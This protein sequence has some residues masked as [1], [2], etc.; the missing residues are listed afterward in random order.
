[1]ALTAPDIIP[2]IS[3]YIVE[4]LD[5]VWQFVKLGL[6][7]G[8]IA[9]AGMVYMFDTRVNV[10]EYSRGGRTINYQ[11]R[12]RRFKDRISG[13]PKLRFFGYFGFKGE[14]IN[15]P[16][17][18]CMVSFKSRL[19]NKMYDFVKK[20]GLYYP[21]QNY[22][23]GVPQKMHKEVIDPKTKKKVIVEYDGFTTEGTGLQVNRDYDAEQAIQNK[24][25]EEALKY[26]NRKPT[27]IIASF[28]LMIITIITAGIIMWYALRNFGSLA[29]AVASLKEPLQQGLQGAAQSIIGPG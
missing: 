3:P 29:G 6:V 27:E 21:V 7:L 10:R 20:D 14:V 1:M 13:M 25:I 15:E 9:Y 5:V 16:P 17:A 23:V 12:A 11:T 28:A 19:T 22:V 4:L 24:L 26:R 2:S 8:V 18:E